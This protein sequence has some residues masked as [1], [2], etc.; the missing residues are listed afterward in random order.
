[1]AV[2]TVKTR[3]IGLPDYAQAKPVGSVPVGVV[4]TSTDVAEL[5]ARQGSPVTF[6]RLGNIFWYED[7]EATISSWALS[8]LT[9]SNEYARHGGLSAKLS[10]DFISLAITEQPYPVLGKL[11]VEFSFLFESADGW[12]LNWGPFLYSVGYGCGGEIVISGTN[13][14]LQIYNYADG[15]YSNI[16]Q[17]NLAPGIFHTI[18][19][20]ADYETHIWERLLLDSK[21][22]DISKY[23]LSYIVWAGVTPVFDLLFF[24]WSTDWLMHDLWFDDVIL[25]YNEP[26]NM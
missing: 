17:L 14:L 3:G 5:A 7:F 13:N 21:V 10:S 16:D 6:D 23:Q 26:A 11:G 19:V 2:Y 18:K 1:M 9:Q 4:H 20:V 15:V 8:D 25:T 22:Y 12:E 24:L